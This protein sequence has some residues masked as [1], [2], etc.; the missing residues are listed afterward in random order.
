MTT[1]VRPTLRCLS[2]GLN[3]FESQRCRRCRKP[4]EKLIALVEIKPEPH[5]PE[6][7]PE[8]DQSDQPDQPAYLHPERAGSQY[9]TSPWRHGRWSDKRAHRYWTNL[10]SV[11]VK[12]LRKHR[13]LFQRELAALLDCPRTYISKI[14]NRKAVPNIP[15]L[16]RIACCLK[17]RLSSLVMSEQELAERVLLNDPFL[18]E[19]R[20]QLVNLD[21]TAQARIIQ[22]ARKFTRS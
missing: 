5:Q 12:T 4:L 10:I 8:P 7:T 19:V 14:E 21:G 11:R 6:P 20:A 15:Q 2:C 13:S 17:I 1:L 16:A 18:A 22:A 3:Q 9:D